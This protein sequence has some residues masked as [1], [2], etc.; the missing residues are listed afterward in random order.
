MSEEEKLYK[1]YGPLSSGSSPYQ[2][3]LRTKARN[4]IKNSK[5]ARELRSKL[6][7]EGSKKVRD[8]MIENI[9][10]NAI[11]KDVGDGFMFGKSKNSYDCYEINQPFKEEE[12]GSL[13]R[14]SKGKLI[15]AQK[16]KFE[17]IPS[18][19]M[20]GLAYA[21]PG[22]K[23]SAKYLLRCLSKFNEKYPDTI[24]IPEARENYIPSFA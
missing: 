5:E 4:Q 8:S 17:I 11:G 10:L 7:E 20:H 3:G 16:R 6:I 12:D 2:K 14:D 23:D 19:T 22:C 1:L 13:A 24:H 9:L 21:I 15:W 18:A